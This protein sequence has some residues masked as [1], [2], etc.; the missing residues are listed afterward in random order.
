[1]LAVLLASSDNVRLVFILSAMTSSSV[2]AAWF[3]AHLMTQLA[4][5]NLLGG[6]GPV[7]V[8][9]NIRTDKNHPETVS[10][11]ESNQHNIIAVELSECTYHCIIQQP[12]SAV[13]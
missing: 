7:N 6:A 8:M 10:Q 4:M 5:S 9:I 13:S 12:I 11:S 3:Q 2:L 1:M